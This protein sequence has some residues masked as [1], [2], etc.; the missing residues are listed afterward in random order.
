[1]PRRFFRVALVLAIITLWQGMLLAG[2]NQ[3]KA[4]AQPIT[5]LEHIVL[6]FKENRSFDHYFGKFPGANGATQGEMHDGTVIDLVPGIDPSPVD[7]GHQNGDWLKA[8]NSGRMNGFDLEKDAFLPNHYPIVYSQM[9][10]S[11]IPN[12]WA[13]ARRFGLADNFFADYQGSS[14]ANNLFR[15]AAQTGKED[16]S[17]GF[18]AAVG[19]PGGFTREGRTRWGCDLPPDFSVQ[20]QDLDGIKS[21]AWPCFTFEALPNLLSEFGVSWKSYADPDSVTFAHLTLDAIA[22]IR[23]DPSLWSNVVPFEQFEADAA[24]GTLP[25][26]SLVQG[27][28][29]DHPA[30]SSVCDGENQFVE[31]VNAVMNGPDWSTTAIVTDW[32]EWGGFYDHVAPPIVDDLSYGFRVP[33]L[34]ISPWVKYGGGSDGGYI[35]STL[36][37]HASPMKLIETNWSL[38]SLTSRDGSAND[39]LDFFDFEQTPKDPLILSTRTCPPATP[40]WLK[41]HAAFTQDKAAEE[42]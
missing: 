38:P 28:L 5:P 2:N 30:E 7:P 40:E 23:Y 35:S 42:S 36:Y 32:D 9:D 39:M 18:R 26:V 6:I 11:Q 19:L 31:L 16:P 41:L 24:A 14:F 17:T 22:Q 3:S 1:M 21:S 33:A 34:V 37:S 27:T 4:S 25:S 15:Y 20:M 29:S 10:E 13:Y 8:Y 12:Y